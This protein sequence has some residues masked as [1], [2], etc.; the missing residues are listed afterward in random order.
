MLVLCPGC[1]GNGEG[2]IRQ[3]EWQEFAREHQLGLAGLSFASIT[4]VQE[5]RTSYYHASK[6]SGQ[7]LL[8]AIR[9]IYGK[10]LPVLL[11]GFSGGAHFTSRFVEWKP[12]RVIAWCAYSAGWWDI[13]LKTAVNPPGIVACGDADPRYGESM[14]YFKQ[15][16]VAGKPWLWIS[17]ARVGHSGSPPLEAFIRQYFAAV[18]K[19][20]QRAGLWVDVDLETPASGSERKE[21]PSL[22]GWIPDIG[23]LDRWKAI[24]E[25]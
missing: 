23:L 15:G 21:E 12:E 11:F 19:H 2:L 17:L 8:E 6:G 4:T 10:D 24:N 22:T 5:N 13:P 14:I 9:K 3:R 16:R 7:A 25:P 20:N 18:L 1:N